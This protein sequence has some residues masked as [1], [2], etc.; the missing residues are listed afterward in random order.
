MRV[1]GEAPG[2]TTRIKRDSGV[3]TLTARELEVA[4]WVAEGRSDAEIA[5]QCCMSVPTVK[6]HLKNVRQ[7]LEVSGRVQLSH[8]LLLLGAEQ[9]KRRKTVGAT[10]G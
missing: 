7:K 8:H 9:E 1:L 5:Q 10:S 2:H 3:S 6:F 4:L